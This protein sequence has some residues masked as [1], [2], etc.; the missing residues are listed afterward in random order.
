MLRYLLYRLA[1]AVPLLILMS[2]FVFFFGQ[3][4]AGDL[5]MNL[6]LQSNSGTFDQGIYDT[7]RHQLHED[8]PAPVRFVQ[9]LGGALHG[10]FGVSYA[11]PGTPSISRMIATSLPISVQL[12]IMAMLITVV[13]GLPLGVIA[14]LTRN[15]VLDRLIVGGATLLSATPAFVL[16]P[17]LMVLL[18][19]KLHWVRTVGLGW[20][21]LF[22]PATLFP[23]AALAAGPLLGVT[24][25]TRASIIQ[26]LAQEYVRTARAKGLSEWRVI[27]RH[28]LRNSLTPVLTTL[29]LATA[30]VL[31]GSIFIE[32]IFNIRGFGFMAV[33]AFRAGDIQTVAATT[34]VTGAI[35]ILMNLLVDLTYGLLDPRVRLGASG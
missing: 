5:A 17:V 16:A 28:V 23:A 34:M 12:G 2:A 24:R 27:T 21:G 4:G 10:D 30:H 26:T 6:T 19:V 1:S 20:Q 35:I 3:Y 13:V 18:V 25:F 7:L 8:V 22:N 33:S 15:S 29:G 11:L 9:F 31:S 14:A 32:T